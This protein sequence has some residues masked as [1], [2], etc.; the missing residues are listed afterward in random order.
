M[1]RLWIALTLCAPLGCS[2]T[3]PADPPLRYDDQARQ[4]IVERPLPP[5][6]PHVHTE[7]ERTQRARQVY[8]RG[9]QLL[10]AAQPRVN[11]AI[12]DFHQALEIDPL[13][14]RAH[15]K[16]GICYYLKGEYELEINEY[17]K[18][19]AIEPRYVAGWLNL[20]N[21]LLTRDRLHD[22]RDAYQRVLELDPSHRLV[23]FNLALVEF[24]LGHKAESLHH[25]RA[26]LD[27]EH[28][29]DTSD[30]ARHYVDLLER[31][32]SEGS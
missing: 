7:L 5:H 19:L 17:R 32:L 4:E 30:Q 11:E 15:L 12:R 26:F 1:R 25:F 27:L 10:E 8:L 18:C 2:T 20:G 16:L 28:N 13:F 9:V 31:Q 23:L 3:E 14:H 22:A 21:A 24:D 29:T 6:E